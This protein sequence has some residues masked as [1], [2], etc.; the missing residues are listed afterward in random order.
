M[1][2][3]LVGQRKSWS[4]ENLHQK[5]IKSE[6][7]NWKSTS[8]K[9]S[10]VRFNFVPMDFRSRDTEFLVRLFIGGACRAKYYREILNLTVFWIILTF[11]SCR[12][13]ARLRTRLENNEHYATHKNYHNASQRVEVVCNQHNHDIITERRKRGSLKSLRKKKVRPTQDSEA[14]LQ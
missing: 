14:Q 11:Y 6:P 7:R 5:R 12:C 4:Q 2:K 10:K 1:L 13:P 8:S 9:A 3:V